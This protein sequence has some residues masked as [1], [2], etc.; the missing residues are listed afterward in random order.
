MIKSTIKLKTEDH[1][2]NKVRQPPM[3]ITSARKNLFEQPL[4][5]ENPLNSN[6]ALKMKK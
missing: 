5:T 1:D 6:D 2:A 3:L 4:V